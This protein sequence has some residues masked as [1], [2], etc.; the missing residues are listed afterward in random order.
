MSDEDDR[1]VAGLVEH[2][3]EQKTMI[4]VL[5]RGYVEAAYDQRYCKDKSAD[6]NRGREALAE[7][8]RS[9]RPLTQDL[10]DLLAALFDPRENSI[11]EANAG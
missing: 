1:A 10:R 6:E 5:L 2:L 11:P 8:L 7:L 4:N 9:G 3:R